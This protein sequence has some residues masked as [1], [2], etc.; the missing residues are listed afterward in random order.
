MEQHTMWK[1]NMRLWRLS[2]GKNKMEDE[3][4]NYEERKERIEEF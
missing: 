3:R 4:Q 2:D 1:E